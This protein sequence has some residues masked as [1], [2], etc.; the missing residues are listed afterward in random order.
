MTVVV[1]ELL[2][3]APS[4][5]VSVRGQ[6]TLS[7][8]AKPVV[9]MLPPGPAIREV[10]TPVK[11]CAGTPTQDSV[12]AYVHVGTPQAEGAPLTVMVSLTPLVTVSV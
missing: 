8:L 11:F 2:L 5:T 6:V 3:P 4:V 9:S 10:D 7:P 12:H 1:V